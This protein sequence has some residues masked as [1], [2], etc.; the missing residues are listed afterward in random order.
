LAQEGND[1]EFEQLLSRVF[2]SILCNGIQALQV[3]FAHLERVFLILALLLGQVQFVKQKL[4]AFIIKSDKA[5][6]VRS[7]IE[8]KNIFKK[9]VFGEFLIQI[10]DL[11]EELQRSLSQLQIHWFA[12]VIGCVDIKILVQQAI[13]I[14]YPECHLV[15]CLP[16]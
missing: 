10:E 9:Y 5:N 13:G 7:D 6:V 4:L 8:N 12:F 2:I 14:S 16:D 15:Q 11:F 3:L 1:L